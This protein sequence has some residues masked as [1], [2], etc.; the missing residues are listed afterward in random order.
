[1]KVGPYQY[2]TCIK[3]EAKLLAPAHWLSRGDEYRHYLTHENDANDPNYQ[4]FE[5]VYTLKDNK[6]V[7][8][9]EI[10]DGLVK[11]KRIIIY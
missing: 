7:A 10:N 9:I 11:P 4:K 2:L 5:R 6:L 3:C 1:M 8:L